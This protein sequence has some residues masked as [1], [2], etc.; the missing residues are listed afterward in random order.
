MSTQQIM[1]S[2]EFKKCAEFH[3][4]ICPGLSIG[5]K[6]ASLAMEKIKAERATD[7]EIVAIVETDACSAD[8]VQVV[9]G[10]TFGKGNFIYKDY[11]KMVLTLLSR[12]TGRGVRVSMRP[13]TFSPDEE[14]H[15]LLHKVLNDEADEKETKRFHE[16]HLKR[17][18]DIL[19]MSYDELFLIKAIQMELPTKAR[20]EPS[21]PCSKCNEPTMASK[22]ESVDGVSICRGC[23]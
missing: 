14:H 12:K 16:L 6:A 9:T 2:E 19:E 20:I 22:L 21:K 18:S 13:R 17:S 8:A 3:G 15:K 5:Y 11:G 23:L 10:C 1:D 4:H 7:E